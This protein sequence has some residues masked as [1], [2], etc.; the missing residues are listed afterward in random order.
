MSILI[1]NLSIKFSILTN[2]K[3][4]LKHKLLTMSFHE[5]F[6]KTLNKVRVIKLQASNNFLITQYYKYINYQV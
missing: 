5:F 2:K 4:C 1:I 6:F 3:K